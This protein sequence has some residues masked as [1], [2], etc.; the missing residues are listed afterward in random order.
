MKSVTRELFNRVFGDPKW[1]FL[2]LGGAQAQLIVYLY[3]SYL[4][5]WLNSFVYSG[6]I[7]TPKEV[8]M[9]FSRMTLYAI[10]TTLA[11]VFLAGY[12]ADKIKPIYMI[13]PA[14][15]GRS[16]V[17]YAFKIVEDP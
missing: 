6:G 14:F 15:F 17:T 3:G 9:V 7:E 13:V 16:F 2:F 12:L 11:T 8:E 10:P 4:V 1:L 5:L